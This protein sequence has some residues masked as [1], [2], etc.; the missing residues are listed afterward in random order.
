ML[1]REVAPTCC[2][3]YIVLAEGTKQTKKEE[4]PARVRTAFSFYRS[5]VTIWT[6]SL[7]TKLRHP[8]TESDQSI[9][10]V[11]GFRNPG[12][13]Q[14][15]SKQRHGNQRKL[16][17]PLKETV[18]TLLAI[19]QSATSP[20]R[21]VPPTRCFV[22]FHCFHLSISPKTL[23]LCCHPKVPSVWS[24]IRRTTAQSTDTVVDAIRP[25]LLII[26]CVVVSRQNCWQ[27]L[28]VSRLPTDSL[29]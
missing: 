28:S 6:E 20:C 21:N 17:V 25:A 19:K 14:H 15:V 1:L 24:W 10:T 4:N 9:G 2:I 26:D 16:C 13:K 23:R 8:Q 29:Y 5:C 12:T 11:Y 3:W 18:G 7:P 22:K 27:I